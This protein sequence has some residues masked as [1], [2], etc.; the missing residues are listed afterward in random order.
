MTTVTL[1]VNGEQHRL[2]VDPDMPFLYALP[3]DPWLN[4]PSI[5]LFERDQSI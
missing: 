5:A 2:D 1:S 4:N 3:D